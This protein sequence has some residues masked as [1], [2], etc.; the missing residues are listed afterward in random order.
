[1]STAQ[2]NDAPTNAV[3]EVCYRH[4]D[5]QTGVSCQRCDR[6]VC[7]ECASQASVG[8]H[9][10]ECKKGSKQEVYTTNTLPGSA[11]L[12]TRAFVGINVAV[13]LVTMAF[14]GATLTDAGPRVYRDYGTFGPLIAENYDLW[15]IV[16]GGFLHSGIIHL[17]FNMYL[18]WMLGLSLEKA[19][20]S[21]D[22]VA[23]YLVSLL[24]GSAGAMLLAPANP[25]V[26]ASGAVFGLIGATVLFHRSRGVG[27]FDTGLGFLIMMNAVFSLRGGVS[28]G[29]HLGGFLAG[30]LLGALFFGMNQGEGPMI[31]EANKRLAATIA[32]G[33]VLF[34]A[35]YLGATTWQAPLFG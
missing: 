18:L 14:L 30:L 6:L 12:A 29:G 16:S 5:R 17:G 13:Y 27:I 31:P 15:R 21:R 9:C 20:G 7:G 28:L 33:L 4:P 23:V 8:V 1:M 2:P 25:V 34:G 24:G 10:P 11:G 19:L 26:G 32:L 22:F 35:A 3:P